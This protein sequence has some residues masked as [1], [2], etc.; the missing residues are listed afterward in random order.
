M[1]KY[2]RSIR[3]DLIN[4]KRRKANEHDVWKWYRLKPNEVLK[5]MKKHDVCV[6]VNI[7]LI[8]KGILA[9]DAFKKFQID[10]LK[11]I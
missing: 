9:V 8:I 7:S 2:I 3:K 11:L 6:A 5:Y 4:R 1:K 10:R